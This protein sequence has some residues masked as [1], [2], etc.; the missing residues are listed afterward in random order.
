MCY[1]RIPLL[2][3]LLLLQPL[4]HMHIHC[5]SEVILLCCHVVVVDFAPQLGSSTFSKFVDLFP[6]DPKC[7][8]T[9]D[10]S[11]VSALAAVTMTL[12]F[13]SK[14]SLDGLDDKADSASTREKSV[15]NLHYTKL[16]SVSET[17]EE[18]NAGQVERRYEKEREEAV[19]EEWDEFLT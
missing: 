15:V 7:R 17:M 18:S 13:L 11:I 3:V 9:S 5:N 2:A 8:T 4:V 10:P 12:P 6:K 1:I 14:D 19:L 16:D